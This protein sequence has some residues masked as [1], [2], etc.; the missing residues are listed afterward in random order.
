MAEFYFHFKL[1][2]FFYLPHGN[3]KYPS[4]FSVKMIVG[5]VTMVNPMVQIPLTLKQPRR[6]QL[7]N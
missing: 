4:I 6:P 1:R 7:I 3:K 2:V 5:S